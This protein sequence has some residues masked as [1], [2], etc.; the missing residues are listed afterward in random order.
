MAG[1]AVAGGALAG[2]R[3]GFIGAGRIGAPM[4]RALAARGAEV[5]VYAR[6]AAVRDELAATGCRAVASIAGLGCGNDL[7]ISCVFSDAQFESIAGQIAAILGPGSVFASHTTGS[8]TTMRRFAARLA[9]EGR[10]AHVVDAPFSGTPDNIQATTLTVLL[11]GEKED[12]DRV[13]PA[14][15]AYAGTVIRTGD[16]GSALVLK[17]INNIVFAANVQVGLEVARLA[18]QAGIPMSSVYQVFAASSGGTKAIGVM[19]Q[20]GAPQVFADQVRPFMVKDVAA[21]EQAAAQLG[22]DLGLLGHVA[23]SGRLDVSQR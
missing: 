20:F 11:G 18:E 23:R 19:E 22:V 13:E 8:P 6:R 1:R 17:L 14:V 16:L 15:R 9:D 5:S 21:C 2:R 3:I 10:D 7:V 12:V 4:A